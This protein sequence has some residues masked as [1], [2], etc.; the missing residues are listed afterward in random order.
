MSTINPSKASDACTACGGKG[1]INVVIGSDDPSIIGS[2]MEMQA[3]TACLGDNFKKTI[4]A[5]SENNPPGHLTHDENGFVKGDSGKRYRPELVAIEFRSGM[6]EILAEGAVEY[7]DDNW[8]KCTDQKRYIGALMRHVEAFERGEKIDPKSGHHTLLHAAC[9][10]MMLHGIDIVMNPPK[11][12]SE[13]I[14]E[15]L[16]DHRPDPGGLY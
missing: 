13:R 5:L 8:R 9:C 14:Q 1:F 3:C 2:H 16:E 15:A 10:I 12:S 11:T 7:G 6:A 4:E